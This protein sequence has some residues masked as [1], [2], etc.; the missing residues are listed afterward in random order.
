MVPISA[1]PARFFRRGDLLLEISKQ[2]NK[3][4][5]SNSGGIPCFSHTETLPLRDVLYFCWF[6]EFPPITWL[7]NHMVYSKAHSKGC[8]CHELEFFSVPRAFSKPVMCSA[9]VCDFLYCVFVTWVL[10]IFLCSHD[11][12]APFLWSVGAL[13]F[14]IK[15]GP[16]PCPFFFQVFF[17]LPNRGSKTILLPSLAV[18]P[19]EKPYARN[20]IC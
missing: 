8:P 6:R 15:N 19:P 12:G 18:L 3:P 11:F 7:S 17:F 5:K 2:T 1:L 10:D 9:F 14:P 4:P 20:A 16:Y 13:T